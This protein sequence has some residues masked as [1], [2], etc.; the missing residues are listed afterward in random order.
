MFKNWEK[1]Q[2]YV[3]YDTFILYALLLLQHNKHWTEVYL[4]V[5]YILSSLE[6]NLILHAK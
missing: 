2:K 3:N 6:Q 4:S 5:K 1:L